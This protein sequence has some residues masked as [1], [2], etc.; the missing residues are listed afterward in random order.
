MHHRQRRNSIR[1]NRVQRGGQVA[2]AS[3]C[4]LLA[5]A[6]LAPGCV[7]RSGGTP[8]VAS[9]I[10]K[11]TK[12]P[13]TAALAE[14]RRLVE[15]VRV[16]PGAHRVNTA[17]VSILRKAFEES[18]S[19]YEL[20]VARWWVLPMSMPSALRWLRAHP[21]AGLRLSG[22][23]EGGN[24]GYSGLIYDD[25]LTW[26]YNEAKLLVEVAPYGRGSSAL[27]LDGQTTWVPLRTKA[28]TIPL[29]VARVDLVA[30]HG[31]SSRV[32][33]RRTLTGSA[34]R[35]LAVLVNGLPRQN[36]EYIS[37]P[38][39]L[40]E[41][42]TRMS[43]GTSQGTLVFTEWCGYVSVTANGRPEPTLFDSPAL[44]NA[45]RGALGLEDTM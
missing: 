18:S 15:A 35:Q 42:N 17:P 19:E 8:A 40:S 14:A 29:D 12:S 16:P 25:R 5:L 1:V 7:N 6:L 37:C 28:E 34:A 2:K 36:F 31:G 27:R 24:V 22:S 30:Y 3:V 39:G 41:I 45:V 21:P 33:A 11:E 4:V 13:Q 9:Q 20:D 32:L 38:E 44:R 23:A 26:A 43:F 10:A